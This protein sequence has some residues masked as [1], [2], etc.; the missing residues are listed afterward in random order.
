MALLLC[1]KRAEKPFYYEKLDLHLWS[2][3]ELCY[4]L[5][6]YPVLVPEDFVDQK[7]L[8]WLRDEL[9]LPQLA[10]RLE[11]LRRA[12]ADLETFMLR[13]QRDG[14][15]YTERELSRYSAELKKLRDLDS[16]HLAERLG[17]TLFRL[18]RYGRAV[19]AY[20]ESVTAKKNAAVLLKLGDAYVTVMQFRKAAAA[21]EEVYTETH[22]REPLRKLYYLR[23]L[24]PSVDTF[25]KYE[26]EVSEE[27]QTEW[28]RNFA[29][30]R[31]KSV[32]SPGVEKIQKMY[33]E[34]EKPFRTAAQEQIRVWKKAYRAML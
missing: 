5:Y 1:S 18:K 19:S 21:Y 32:D 16:A 9:E 6:H 29:D 2:L 28:D 27:E 33:S 10:E 30:A 24:E 14:N 13:I 8:Q 12:G 23:Q 34:G 31:Q 4:V 22:T 25:S 20:R 26:N 11:Q 17:D 15:Y 3:Q 7:L